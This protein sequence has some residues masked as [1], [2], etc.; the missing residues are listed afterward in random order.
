LAELL[1]TFNNYKL[2]AG[3]LALVLVAG[4]TSPAFAQPGTLIQQLTPQQCGNLGGIGVAYD[5][6]TIWYTCQSD[7][8]TLHKTD[9]NSASNGS[10]PVVDAN[11]NPVV[12]DAIAWDTNENTMWGTNQDGAGTCNIF[13]VDVNTGITSPAFSFADANCNFTF[14]DGIT[15]DTVTDTIYTSADVVSTIHHFDKNGNPAA[16]DLIP[17]TALTSGG[18]VPACGDVG[19]P[20]SGLAIGLDGTLFAG[21]NGF[22]TIVTLDPNTPAF[23]SEFGT[24]TGRDEGLTCGPTVQGLETILS[25]DLNSNIIDVLETADG[26]CIDPTVDKQ[27][28]AG[29]LLPLDSTALLIGGLSSM[30]VFMIPAVASIAGAAVYLVKFRANE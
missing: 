1:M 6:A 7:R 13:R 27:V 29:E 11:N 21:T 20:N 3:A 2:L 5:G 10:V 18:V 15:I 12:V 25:R 4:M 14:Y 9:L 17:F 28:V 8:T 23:L 19:C 16:N 24:A 30:S 22:G 26:T